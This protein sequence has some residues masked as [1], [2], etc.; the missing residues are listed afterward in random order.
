MLKKISL[1]LILFITL[2]LVL[3]LKLNVYAVT[4]PSDAV[5]YNGH[6]YKVFELSKT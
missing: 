1:C 3:N 5:N 6:A 2:G 4:I